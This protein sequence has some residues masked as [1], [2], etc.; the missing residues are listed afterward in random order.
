[1]ATKESSLGQSNQSLPRRWSIRL[2]FFVTAVIG[3][4]IAGVVG[5]L[6]VLQSQADTLALVRDLHFGIAGLVVILALTLLTLYLLIQNRMKAYEELHAS[7]Q[8]FSLLAGNV[9]NYAILLLDEKGYVTSWGIGAQRIKGYAPAEIIGRH[10]SSFY[11]PEDIA[12][13]KPRAELEAAE[14]AGR[15]ED[16]GWRVRKDGTLFWAHVVITAIRD[17]SGAL[18]GFGKVTQDLTERKAQDERL[19]AEIDE[20]RRM[21]GQLRDLNQGLEDRVQ[22][23]TSELAA[24]NRALSAEVAERNRAEV[25]VSQTKQRL[26]GI[27]DSAMDAI[28][29]TDEDQIIVL[30]NGAAQSLFGYSQAEA[31]G[32]PL[33]QL[34]PQRYRMDHGDKMREFGKE[35]TA[36]RRM[37]GQR[38]VTA[39][40]RDGAEFPIDASISRLVMDGKLFYTVILRDVTE[41]IRREKE[42]R[43]SREQLHEMAAS[44]QAAR[45]QEKG[46]IARELHDE[47][48]QLLTSMKMDL[49][50][51]RS[52]LATE[53]ERERVDVMDGLL[54]S[55]VAATRRISSDLRPLMLD[56]LGLIPA[57]EW[58]LENFSQRTG[59]DYDFD[60][61]PRDLDLPPE[62]A[63]ALYR[64]L[65]E[66]LTN[67]S[68]H[69]KATLIEVQLKGTDAMVELTVRDNGVGFDPA[70]ARKPMSFGLVG[71]RERAYFLGGSVAVTTTLGKGTEVK[72]SIPLGGKAGS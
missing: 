60:V 37:G 58:L 66:S 69:A 59:V 28:I 13:D 3:I 22:A 39:L 40:R 64:V 7:E 25:E 41:D 29:T 63:T 43:E 9:Q 6:V 71:L 57:A 50:G 45:E 68:K 30:F 20:R 53:K 15:M 1:M 23:R 36:S 11:R 42:L 26:T 72:A 46:R 2:G 27:I 17:E 51:L 34:I 47:L 55:M 65:Q 31:I 4:A 12:A 44:A 32:M 38:V 8:L 67:I 54:D 62:H 21:E 24:T 14:A 56:D 18:R 5:R 33:V 52:E 48:G 19:K 49:S 70:A 16:E 10:F 61:D 35:V